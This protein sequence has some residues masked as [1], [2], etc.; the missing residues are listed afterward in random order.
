MELWALA[1]CSEEYLKLF[2]MNKLLHICGDSFYFITLTS[3]SAAQCDVDK[4]FELLS[5]IGCQQLSSWVPP[6]RGALLNLL[7]GLLCAL[8]E[9]NS[10]YG[11]SFFL[12]LDI[13]VRNPP[14][15]HDTF[16]SDI[17]DIIKNI[18]NVPRLQH[19]IAN[20]D[21][22]ID[23]FYRLTASTR[24]SWETLI[25]GPTQFNPRDLTRFLALPQPP[26]EDTESAEL[27][28]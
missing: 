18:D 26:I 7:Q 27:L 9:R 14:V 4:D 16:N 23:A 15:D 11:I 8:F 22:N 5:Q 13:F 20:I 25:A 24:D 6:L 3:T 2:F 10:L 28:S 12:C 19:A 17:S 1:R 21:S